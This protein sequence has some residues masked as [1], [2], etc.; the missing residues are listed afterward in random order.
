MP[1]CRPAVKPERCHHTGTTTEFIRL[2]GVRPWS[3]EREAVRDQ[4]ALAGLNL[5]RRAILG[6][7]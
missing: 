2:A 3:R 5:L 4:S 6:L 1:E 7:P